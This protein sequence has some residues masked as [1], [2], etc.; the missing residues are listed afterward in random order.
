MMLPDAINHKE[1]TD[2]FE[3]LGIWRDPSNPRAF[4]YGILTY[5]PNNEAILM[6]LDSYRP[7]VDSKD[8]LDAFN[9]LLMGNKDD[10]IILGQSI[11]GEKITLFNSPRSENMILPNSPR[12]DV[13]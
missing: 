1:L 4:L 5:T 9:K 7:A 10:K 13:N 2:T 8:N 12:K 6:T 3:C 11:R